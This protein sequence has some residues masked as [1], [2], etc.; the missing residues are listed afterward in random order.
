V[1]DVLYVDSLPFMGFERVPPRD[2]PLLQLGVVAGSLV[3]LGLVVVWPFSALRRRGR[4]PVRGETSATLLAFAVAA[5]LLVFT[6]GLAT[7]LAEANEAV[8]GL[9]PTF[10]KLL[11]IPVGIL[12]V[13]LALLATTSR[14][15]VQSYWWPARRIHYTL[16][17]AAAWAYVAWLFYWQVVAIPIP[18]V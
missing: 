4:T 10:E 1:A 12:P 5:V 14:A 3:I 2:H 8:F 17:T 16:V 7:T 18:I 9:S 15:W 6:V 13:L 11:W